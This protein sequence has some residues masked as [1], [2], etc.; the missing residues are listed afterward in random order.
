MEVRD[1]VNSIFFNNNKMFG[2]L[3]GEEVLTCNIIKLAQRFLLICSGVIAIGVNVAHP[4]RWN[5]VAPGIRTLKFI[6]L[7]HDYGKQIVST[8]S[9]V[10]K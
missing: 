5:A 4:P 9:S 7:A 3:N 8:K 10:S 1:F 2:C 6:G